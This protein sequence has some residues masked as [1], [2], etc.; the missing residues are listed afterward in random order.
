VAERQVWYQID[1]EQDGTRL[2]RSVGLSGIGQAELCASVGARRD[3]EW[4]HQVLGVLDFV[5]GYVL[6]SN[7]RI[8]SGETLQFGWTLL[9]FIERTPGMLEAH[10]IEDVYSETP[11]PAFVAGVDRAVRLAAAADDVMRRNGLAGVGDFPYRGKLAVAC[12]HLGAARTPRLHIERMEV[13]DAVQDSGWVVNCGVDGDN[14]EPEDC[15]L[16]HLAHV[17]A[18]W[19]FVV[20]YLTLPVG[21]EV[22]FDDDGALVFKPG[23]NEGRRDPVDPYAFGP[24]TLEGVS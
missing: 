2:I 19:P 6:R 12:K 16:T 1:K 20:P 21:S 13:R 7:A 8:R 17:A 11:T 22:L 14:H 3:H 4:D 10:E 5:A 24:W 15:T 9:Q 18:D 23:H